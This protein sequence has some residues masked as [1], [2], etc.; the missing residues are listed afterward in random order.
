MVQCIAVETEGQWL[1]SGGSDCSVRLWEV[2][3]GRCV[4]TLPF[5]SKPVGVAFPPTTKHSIL[6]IAA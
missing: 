5:P 4:Q 1:A 3:T 6:A 2:A